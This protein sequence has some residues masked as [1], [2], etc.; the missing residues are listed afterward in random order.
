M[1]S[2]EKCRLRVS[3]HWN[4]TTQLIAAVLIVTVR[5][6]RLTAYNWTIVQSRSRDSVA[7]GGMERTINSKHRK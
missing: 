4:T 6:F 2:V 7:S 1:I 5:K 3:C